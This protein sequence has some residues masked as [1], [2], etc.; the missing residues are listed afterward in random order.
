MAFWVVGCTIGWIG[1]FVATVVLVISAPGNQP[2]GASS[3]AANAALIC[4]FLSACGLTAI[5][6][7]RTQ[8]GYSALG[9]SGIVSL[10]AEMTLLLSGARLPLAVR[11]IRNG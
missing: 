11:L 7:R 6:I 9:G 8:T 4:A 3:I 1:G 10:A 2:T 5:A